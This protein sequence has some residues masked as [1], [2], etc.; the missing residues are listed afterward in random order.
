MYKRKFRKHAFKRVK[1]RFG[2]DLTLHEINK[3]VTTIHQGRCK[4]LANDRTTNIKIL[5]V[6]GMRM[7]FLW[8]H[9]FK[10]VETVLPPDWEKNI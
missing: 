1:E 2:I 6:R 3:I 9:K 7:C 5:E 10:R 4:T 8:N